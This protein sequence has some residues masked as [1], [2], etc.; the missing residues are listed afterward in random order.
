MSAPL[1]MKVIGNW[2][3]WK[4]GTDV[5]R[6][7]VGNRGPLAWYDNGTLPVNARWECT[8]Y[9]FNRVYRLEVAA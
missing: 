1:P 3:Y 4:I 2:E 6:N 5:Y 9:Y 7:Q 8:I